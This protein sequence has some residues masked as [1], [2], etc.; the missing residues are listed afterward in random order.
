MIKTFQITWHFRTA[1]FPDITYSSC[2]WTVY[3]WLTTVNGKLQNMKRHLVS[4][5]YVFK[6]C[7]VHMSGERVD[8]DENTSQFVVTTQKKLNM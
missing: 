3:S 1:V 8:L 5:I 2:T 6:M 7:A 4:V